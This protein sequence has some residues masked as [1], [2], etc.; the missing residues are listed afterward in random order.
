LPLGKYRLLHGNCR[1]Q[2][3]VGY[4]VP[5]AAIDVSIQT[6]HVGAHTPF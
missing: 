3:T 1:E 5:T 4:V 2:Y 6:T